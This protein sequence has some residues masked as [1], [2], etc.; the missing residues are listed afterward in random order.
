MRLLAILAS[1][2]FLGHGTAES[3]REEQAAGA[4]ALLLIIATAA[5]PTKGDWRVQHWRGGPTQATDHDEAEQAASD[6]FDG[7]S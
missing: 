3:N 1:A 2:F 7:G 6:W 4:A 5:I